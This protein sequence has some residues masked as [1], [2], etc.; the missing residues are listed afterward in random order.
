MPPP[1][2]RMICVVPESR[3]GW[4]PSDG[5][6]SP[7]WA[8]FI[9]FV[10][11]VIMDSSNL[12]TWNNW[13]VTF[14]ADLPLL[15]KSVFLV[16]FNWLIT[17]TVATRLATRLGQPSQ[18]KYLIPKSRRFANFIVIS[19]DRSRLQMRRRG[20]YVALVYSMIAAVRTP[21]TG[22][23]RVIWVCTCVIWLDPWCSGPFS[24]Q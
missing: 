10:I 2:P 11:H 9:D 1:C 13:P 7:K 12:S 15:W 22:W 17:P 21:G 23:K 24:S 16:H 3:T 19:H 8:Y 6:R 5:K 14:L 18:G 4:N 20:F